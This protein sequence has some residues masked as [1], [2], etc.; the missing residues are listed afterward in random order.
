M[1]NED[2]EQMMPCGMNNSPK[3][4][5]RLRLLRASP[6][7]TNHTG[8]DETFTGS[9]AHLLSCSQTWPPGSSLCFPIISGVGQL[10]SEI[11]V[12]EA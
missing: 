9:E 11:R 6:P 5:S 7:E 10:D 3:S 8:V 2:E 4:S 1:R 12:L